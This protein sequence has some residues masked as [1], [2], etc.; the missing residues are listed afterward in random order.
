VYE[1]ALKEISEYNSETVDYMN[2]SLLL[3]ITQTAISDLKNAKSKRID[4]F[5][6]MDI[7]PMSLLLL[8]QNFDSEHKV[9]KY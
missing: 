2:L 5:R 3:F 1:Q 4:N 7:N 8:L 9:G 6:A